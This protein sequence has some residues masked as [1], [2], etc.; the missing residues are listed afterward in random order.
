MIERVEFGKTAFRRLFIRVPLN[1]RGR[2]AQELPELGPHLK[3]R[4]YVGGFH[5]KRGGHLAPYLKL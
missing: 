4:A 5:A 1:P 2:K 3:E